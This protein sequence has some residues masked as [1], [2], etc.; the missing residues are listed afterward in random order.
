MKESNNLDHMLGQLI[1]EF[2]DNRAAVGL[3][4]T[5]DLTPL[6]AAAMYKPD[7]AMELI[8]DGHECDIHSACALGLCE[9]IERL[10]PS[11]DLSKVAEHL[12][13]MGFALVK[14]SESAVRVLLEN[15]DDPN[16]R[17]QR[18][19]FFEWEIKT[20]AHSRWRPIHA[21]CAHGYSDQAAA[22]VG[23]LLDSGAEIS[24]VS[25]LGE[26]GIHLAAT[27]GWERVIEVLLSRGADIDARTGSAEPHVVREASP[28]N[29]EEVHQQTPLMI[30]IR[31]GAV[32]AVRL[33]LAQGASVHARDSSGSTPLHVAASPWWSESV[34]IANIL[35]EAGA[36]PSARNDRDESAYDVAIRAG[37]H[38]TA[39]FLAK[40]RF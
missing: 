16:Q 21:A 8:S 10:A 40:V 26:Q 20:L 33:F 27:Y 3:G 31:E 6:Q 36:D 18:I 35:I 1:L 13:P 30:S 15:G 23:V 25:M 9:T 17:M 32:D 4:L 29:A 14:Q 2:R 24:A 37:K 28:E 34:E 38:D 12:T 19:G 7:L 39:E 22:I 5:T 11:A